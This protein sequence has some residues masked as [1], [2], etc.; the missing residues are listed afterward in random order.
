MQN[1]T[2]DNYAKHVSFCSSKS[3]AMT[4]VQT[5]ESTTCSKFFKR[6]KRPVMEANT[7]GRVYEH[8]DKTCLIQNTSLD[9]AYDVWVNSMR[10][11]VQSVEQ[12]PELNKTSESLMEVFFDIYPQNEDNSKS[13]DLNTSKFILTIQINPDCTKTFKFLN[14]EQ[15]RMPISTSRPTRVTFKTKGSTDKYTS[16]IVLVDKFTRSLTPLVDDSVLIK[17]NDTS[18]MFC[19]RLQNDIEENISLTIPCFAYT[20]DNPETK[21]DYDMQCLARDTTR[22]M[23]NG[24]VFPKEQHIAFLSK[25]QAQKQVTNLQKY[26]EQLLHELYDCRRNTAFAELGALDH[27]VDT[28]VKNVDWN[29][30]YC[31]PLDTHLQNIIVLARNIHNNIATLSNTAVNDSWLSLP[32]QNSEQNAHIHTNEIVLNLRKVV[33]DL[34]NTR[35]Q[36]TGRVAGRRRDL[37]SVVRVRTSFLLLGAIDDA[38][39][40]VCS[41]CSTNLKNK[42]NLLL[43][44]NISCHAYW[45]GQMKSNIHNSISMDEECYKEACSVLEQCRRVKNSSQTLIPACNVKLSPLSAAIWQNMHLQGLASKDALVV[46]NVPHFLYKQKQIIDYSDVPI[47][48][49]LQ[50]HQS[51]SSQQ[52]QCAKLFAILLSADVEHRIINNDTLRAIEQKWDLACQKNKGALDSLF[53]LFETS[54]HSLIRNA[55]DG[56]SDTVA[57]TPLDLTFL[58]NALQRTAITGYNNFELSQIIKTSLLNNFKTSGISN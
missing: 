52:Y 33:C 27:N 28:I 7:S 54:L 40:S 45:L 57:T 30:S 55:I 2:R 25:E 8:L 29:T 20:R 43:A 12:A 16:K 3:T 21:E 15:L 5:I 9:S 46:A 19:T 34:L 4:N 11:P 35:S 18:L 23:N 58:N 50:K 56:T 51:P 26:Q 36:I 32:L 48:T 1:P 38:L 17:P 14:D 49:S 42:D 13:V 53:S 41:S 6:Q 44:D 47:L 39:R 24:V 22:L 37:Q 10:I 31:I